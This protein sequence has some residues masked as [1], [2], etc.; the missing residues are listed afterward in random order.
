MVSRMHRWPLLSISM[1]CWIM[2]QRL[3][4]LQVVGSG[5][6]RLRGISLRSLTQLLTLVL[7]ALPYVKGELWPYASQNILK[8]LMDEIQTERGWTFKT[9]MEPEFFLV[10]HKEDGG[11]EIADSLDTSI[12]PCYHAYGIER[13]W[14]YLSK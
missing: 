3:L 8:R 5:R 10:R 6:H 12:K 9:G 11:I 2:V 13:A 1:I 4:D 14:P 7:H